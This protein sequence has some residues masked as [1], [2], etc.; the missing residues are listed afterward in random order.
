MC[1]SSSSQSQIEQQQQEQYQTL[2]NNY[3]QEYGEDQSVLNGLTGALQPII[4]AGPSQMGFSNDQLNNLNA[5]AMQSAAQ[6]YAQEKQA[7]GENEAASG[8]SAY[9]P[10]G[11]SQQIE[12][13]LAASGENQLSGEKNQILQADYAQGNQNYNNAV[14]GAEGVAGLLNPTAAGGLSVQGGAA[15]GTTANQIAQ[16]SNSIWGSVLGT[17]GGVAGAAMGNPSGLM[18]MF[19]G[20][21]ANLANG[22]NSINAGNAAI[23]NMSPTYDNSGL[24]GL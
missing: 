17:L 24:P 23:Q 21:G 15:A 7:V 18:S 13:E 19:G 4:Q 3:G 12:G 10:S 11:A 22:M 2:S 20:A 1:G 6:G 14:Q 5:S 16:A 9:I 8:G